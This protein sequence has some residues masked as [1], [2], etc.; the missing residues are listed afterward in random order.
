MIFS[1]NT[2]DENLNSKFE[3]IY[4]AYSKYLYS[5]GINILKDEQYAAD[6]L[7]HCFIK[8]FENIEKIG[9]VNSTQ[10]KSFISIIMRNES[11]N[12]LRKRKTLFRVTESMDETLYILIDEN[13]NTE[14]MLLKAELRNEVRSYLSKLNREES[15]LIILKYGK[16]YTN[17][18]IAEVLGVSQDVVRQRLS[19]VRR[20]LA[21]LIINDREEA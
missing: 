6:A 21:A 12:L 15:N 16:E 11:I 7:Q 18:E 14:E 8:I 3:A 10:T 9:E 1:V 4:F 5:I 20:K 2:L 17:E 13:A 19:R